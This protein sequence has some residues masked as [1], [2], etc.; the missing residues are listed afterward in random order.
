MD[1]MT[2]VHKYLAVSLPSA[3]PTKN[4]YTLSPEFRYCAWHDAQVFVMPSVLHSRSSN[5]LIVPS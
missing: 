3:S 5:R 1:R 4:I 2:R